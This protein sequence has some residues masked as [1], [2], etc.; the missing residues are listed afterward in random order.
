MNLPV[1]QEAVKFMISWATVSF[2]STSLLHGVTYVHVSDTL[3]RTAS[4]NVQHL[5][6][7][8]EYRTAQLIWG[9]AEFT[10]EVKLTVDP[11]GFPR[12]HPP[13]SLVSSHAH[14]K[15]KLCCTARLFTYWNVLTMI[16]RKGTHF[17]RLDHKNCFY[18]M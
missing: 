9:E 17:L 8:T 14:E 3:L 4:F 13:M 11:F 1:P 6:Q 12:N 16:T 18:F 5:G 10:W 15:L 2:W 7:L